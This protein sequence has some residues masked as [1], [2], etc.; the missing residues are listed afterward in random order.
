MF[1]DLT[2]RLRSLIRRRAVEQE[3]DDE[4]RFHLERLVDRH[5][6]DGLA[7]DEAMR[8]ARLEMGGFDKSRRSTGMLGAYVSSKISAATCGTPFDKSSDR[9]ASRCSRYSA[10]ALASAPI[11]RFSA[12]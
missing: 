5:V 2:H 1:T 10:S 3:L 12:R 11:R 6:A 9:P 8:R 7:H 4:L